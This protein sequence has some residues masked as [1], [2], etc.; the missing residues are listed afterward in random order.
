MQKLNINSLHQRHTGL[1][2]ALSDAY[3]EA[4]CVC[5]NRHHSSPVE[6]AI[7]RNAGTTKRLADFEEPTANALNAW[8]NTIDTTEAGAYCMSLAAVEIEEQLV[9]VKR[10]ETLTGADWYVATIGQEP[11]DLETCLRLEVSGTDSGNRSVVRTRL[12]EK[13]QQTKKGASNLP[14]VASV[15]GFRE[16]IIAIQRVSENP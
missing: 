11:E 12:I 8:A 14:A 13:V 6:I 15:V 7:L 10:A 3:Y 9:A 4:A 5:L 16:K 1:T 2:P